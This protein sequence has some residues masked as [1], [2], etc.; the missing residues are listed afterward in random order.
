MYVFLHEGDK[1]WVIGQ[2]GV[3]HYG[4]VVSQWSKLRVIHNSKATGRVV[5]DDIDSFS[6]GA[7]INIENRAYPGYESVIT[8]RAFSLLGT[9][10]DLLFNC[11]HFVNYVYTG[12]AESPQL[13]NF[14][15]IGIVIGFFVHLFS[16]TSDSRYDRRA[17]C[18]RDNTGRF[19]RG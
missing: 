1:V 9:E 16:S 6:G 4:I 15:G 18:Y 12:V 19:A 11:E 13:Q 3:R 5:I 14:V 7:P 2:A 10:Y 8:E 17:R